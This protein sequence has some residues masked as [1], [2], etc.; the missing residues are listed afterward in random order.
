MEQVKGTIRQGETVVGKITA[1]IHVTGGVR[2]QW[3]GVAALPDDVFLK[4]RD[5]Y[6]FE[7]DDG[8]MGKF[9]QGNC[10]MGSNQETLVELVFTNGFE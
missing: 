8:R 7:A 2:R 1:Q 3:Q 5:V 10:S 9:F 4:P 6:T